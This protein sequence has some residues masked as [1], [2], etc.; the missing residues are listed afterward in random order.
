[1]Y[2]Y[3]CVCVTLFYPTKLAK[4]KCWVRPT[5]N[6]PTSSKFSAAFPKAPERQEHRPPF[7]NHVTYNVGPSDVRWLVNPMKTSCKYHKP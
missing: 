7:G 2:V 1:M 3:V 6:R 4:N 5:E